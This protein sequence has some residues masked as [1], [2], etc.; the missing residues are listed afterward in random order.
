MPLKALRPALVGA[1]FANKQATLAAV[2]SY[3]ACNA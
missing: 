3:F 1:G 2:I